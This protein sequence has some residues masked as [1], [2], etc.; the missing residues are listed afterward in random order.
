M[1]SVCPEVRGHLSPSS[2]GHSLIETHLV[3]DLGAQPF[4]CWLDPM[5]LQ[6]M[7]QGYRGCLQ[8]SQGHDICD[9]V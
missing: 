5:H 2:A 6:E 7:A 8:I 9:I 4:R 1:A 3:L